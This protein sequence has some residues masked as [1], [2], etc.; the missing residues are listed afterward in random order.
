VTPSFPAIAAWIRSA[1]PLAVL[2]GA[3]KATF[4]LFSR[5]ADVAVTEAFHERPQVGHGH[6]LGLAHVDAAQ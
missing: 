5:V 1:A 3:E 4:P 6:P 2:P